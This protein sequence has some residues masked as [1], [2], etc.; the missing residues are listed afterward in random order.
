LV[1]D[2]VEVVGEPCLSQHTPGVATDREHL[3]GLNGVMLVEGE[4]LR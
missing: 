3:A 4:D 1:A 2:E